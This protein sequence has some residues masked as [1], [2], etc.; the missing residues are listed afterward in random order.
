LLTQKEA[1]ESA[2]ISEQQREQAVRVATVPKE[3][4]EAAIEGARRQWRC[5]FGNSPASSAVPAAS[6]ASTVRPNFDWNGKGPVGGMGY[7]VV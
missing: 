1:A 6:V 4:F 5:T 3:S 2:G 7:R